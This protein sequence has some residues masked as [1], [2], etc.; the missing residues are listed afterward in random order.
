MSVVAQQTD[1]GSDTKLTQKGQGGER[2]S[3]KK[4]ERPAPKETRKFKW[5]APEG[6]Q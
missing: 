5:L 2:T 1:G 3:L 4:I 6:N